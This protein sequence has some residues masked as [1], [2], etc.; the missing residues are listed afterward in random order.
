[1]KTTILITAT[2]LGLAAPCFAQGHGRGQ[3]KQD[4]E[5]PRKEQVG[6][7]EQKREHEMKPRRG[8]IKCPKCGEQIKLPPP[9]RGLPPGGPRG[10]KHG[11]PPVPQ[12]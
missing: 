6:E 12:E 2:I 11:Q 5:P 7:R 10:P 4:G 3:G 1:M 8:E 9:P